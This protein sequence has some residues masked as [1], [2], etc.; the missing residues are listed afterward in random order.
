M[1]KKIINTVDNKGTFNYFTNLDIINDVVNN[2]CLKRLCVLFM[3]NR[4]YF[5]IVMMLF[6]VQLIDVGCILNIQL[7]LN[8]EDER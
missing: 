8:H 7:H 4:T 5:A 1:N 3:K 2:C 6:T